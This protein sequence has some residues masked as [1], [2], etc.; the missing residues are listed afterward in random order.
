MSGLFTSLA[1][2]LSPRGLTAVGNGAG[3]GGVA[4]MAALILAA[5]ASLYTARSMEALGTGAKRA[6]PFDG[7]AFGL[8][9]AARL[10]TLTVLAVSWLGIAGYA[11]NEIFA[12]W[13]PNLAASFLILGLAAGACFLTD[14]SG[15]DL[16][17]GC[18]TLA[19]CAFVYVAI[20]AT[21]P[22]G[23]GIG[24]PSVVPQFFSPFMPQALEM[25]G[26]LGWL[27]ILFLAV[28]VFAGFDLPL[29]FEN[30]SSRVVPAVILILGAF[31][32]FIWGALLV[33]VPEKLAD[34]Y[35]PHLMVAR[36]VFGEGGRLLM[37]STI[38]LGTFAALFSFFQILGHRLKGIITEEYAH[39]APRVAA[40]V[41]AIVLGALLATGWAGEDALESLI[42][43]GLCFWF[44]AYTLIDLLNIIA[45]RK[46]G[47]RPLIAL[48]VMFIHLIAAIASG[49]Y[50][51]FPLFFYYALGAMT[52]A[53]LVFG[54]SYYRSGIELSKEQALVKTES[55]DENSDDSGQKNEQSDD[56]PV[57]EGLNIVEY[58]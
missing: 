19:F 41:L 38:V 20:M 26:Y 16:Y 8:L 35:V 1:V 5:A 36:N 10:F 13:F 54:V 51:E 14:K 48:P 6:T 24:Y 25:S 34:T 27:D 30:K 50:I 44:A 11:V 49:M 56:E 18:L 9:D 12:L 17:G 43:A 47:G 15:T 40:V 42:S 32:L 53:G 52:V 2:M 33:A 23:A 37:G 46:A 55:V 39:H 21:Q 45:I 58:K 31:L 4:F 3:F 57:A 29:V 28:L 22:V 7:F